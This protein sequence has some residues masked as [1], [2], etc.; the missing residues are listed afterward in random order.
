MTGRLVLG[1][2]AV[3]FIPFG[4][5]ALADP[6]AVARFTQV[7]LPTPTALADGR[8]VYGGLTLGLGIFF[9]LCANRPEFI[10]AGLWAVLLTLAGP[11]SGRVIGVI[12]DGAGTV[13]TY[14]TL[15]AEFALASMA[16]ISLVRET[17]T[18]TN[19]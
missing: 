7:E 5:W 10:R 15:V 11:L 19:S 14:R 9:V 18:N 4:V 6:V 1:L 13:E 3:I 12:V 17:H 8:A 2:V 16:A